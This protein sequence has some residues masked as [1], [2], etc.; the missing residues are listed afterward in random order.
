LL[1]HVELAG[2]GICHEGYR[3]CF[4][5]SLDESGEPAIVEE[6]TFSP[7]AVYGKAKPQ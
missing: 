6:K 7:Y 1:I 3:S 5:R 2:P 4:F